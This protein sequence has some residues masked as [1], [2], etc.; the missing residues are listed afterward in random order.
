MEIFFFSYLKKR[1]WYGI[2]PSDENKF[3]DFVNKLFPESKKECEEFMRHKTFMVYPGIVK[4]KGIKIHKCIQNPG[5][6][7]VTLGKC[8][9][10]GFNMGYNCAEAVNFA[11]KSWLTYGHKAKSCKCDNDSVKMDMKN[12]MKNMVKRKKQ[13]S[14]KKKI[15]VNNNIKLR[16]KKKIKDKKETNFL[17][18]KTKRAEEINYNTRSV[19]RKTL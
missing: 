12:F 17:N 9:H 7:V 11:T 18:K 10:T 2:D 5:E 19:K 6:F 8:Y 1:F 15:D 3:N 16:N 4:S 14:K 13:N